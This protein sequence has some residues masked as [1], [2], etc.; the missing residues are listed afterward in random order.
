MSDLLLGIFLLYLLLLL[1]Y[2]IFRSLHFFSPKSAAALFT[3]ALT[4]FLL[5]RIERDQPAV[6]C[7]STNRDTKAGETI[8]GTRKEAEH[9]L[10]TI[11]DKPTISGPWWWPRVAGEDIDRFHGISFRCRAPVLRIEPDA[12]LL[13]QNSEFT[14]GARIISLGKNQ[15]Q[16]RLQLKE[17]IE[18][19]AS[20]DVVGLQFLSQARKQNLW[21]M[22][23][24]VS[25][26]EE[27][28][29]FALGS[30]DSGVVIYRAR[31][32]SGLGDPAR[33]S[34]LPI[35]KVNDEK[36]FSPLGLL[37]RDGE[38]K[39][40]LVG[41]KLE[42]FG[43]YLPIGIVLLPHFVE[44][45]SMQGA[46][47]LEPLRLLW[48]LSFAR[49]FSWID[50]VREWGSVPKAWY[51][52]DSLAYQEPPYWF[53]RAGCAA[54]LLALLSACGFAL[55]RPRRQRLNRRW[56][57]GVALLGTLVLAKDLFVIWVL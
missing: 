51:Q 16:T 22:K 24:W 46:V 1:P 41:N 39:T 53:F 30:P 43:D 19:M 21:L 5:S 3:A 12:N 6:I 37:L 29:L 42:N 50:L 26:P 45:P 17:T 9:A 49:G 48:R 36:V 18:A 20:K 33:P 25:H 15:T 54:F 7:E 27:G 31:A 44:G 34:F 32:L 47:L 11:K 35:R 8:P 10:L 57:L 2:L 13:L 55:R 23:D 28:R 52:I 40:L 14:R 4:L 56:L 38:I